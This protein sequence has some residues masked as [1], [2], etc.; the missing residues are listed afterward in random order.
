MTTLLTCSAYTVVVK[1][2]ND[3][4]PPMLSLTVATVA[5]QW[6]HYYKDSINSSHLLSAVLPLSLQEYKTDHLQQSDKA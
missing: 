2:R 6:S 1:L 4:I 3:L 5:V